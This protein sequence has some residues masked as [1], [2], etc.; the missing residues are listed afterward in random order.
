M[1]WQQ[2]AETAWN[3]SQALFQQRQQLDGWL[4]ELT[5]QLFSQFVQVAWYASMA[6]E[7]TRLYG[8][9]IVLGRS[10]KPSICFAQPIP[11]DQQSVVKLASIV[12]QG[13]RQLVVHVIDGQ[14]RIV[15]IRD[16]F[17]RYRRWLSHLPESHYPDRHLMLRIVAPGH[18]RLGYP[19]EKELCRGSEHY[20][21]PLSYAASLQSWFKE[22]GVDLDDHTQG[23]PPAPGPFAVLRIWTQILREVLD[24]ERGGA[25]LVVPEDRALWEPIL[26]IAPS[27]R[28]EISI[29]QD[30]LREMRAIEPALPA[31]AEVTNEYSARL[32]NMAHFHERDLQLATEM[33]AALTRVDGAVVISRLLRL[34]AFGA[35][36]AAEPFTD[37]REH[38]RRANQVQVLPW[39]GLAMRGARHQSAVNF[40]AA[41]PGAIAV[42]ISQDGDT[43][44]FSS[45]GDYVAFERI[46]LNE[47]WH[48]VE[49]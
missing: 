2:F 46:T 17:F 25:F 27:H 44:V 39:D 15:G 45:Q 10:A 20:L 4:R 26:Q 35:K 33:V 19:I 32:I 12:K 41:V 47:D 7:E 40:V 3:Q 49:R 22:V 30:T 48:D 14:L 28:C 8:S 9:R 16:P 5:P 21:T 31:Y 24:G 23:N 42:V 29:L 36:I 34:V 37:V 38:V 43:S 13:L 1:E 6:T 18:I 11:Y